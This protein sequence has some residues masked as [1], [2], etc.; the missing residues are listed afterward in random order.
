MKRRAFMNFVGLGFVATSLPVAIAACAPEPE[1]A[2]PE[3]PDSA[4][5][6]P[7]TDV[8]ARTDGFAPLGSVGDLDA[9]GFLADKDFAAGPVIVIRDPND[10]A[11]V[12]ALDSTCTHTGCAVDWAGTEFACPCHGSK[13]SPTGEV[14]N[15]PAN[16]PLGTYEAKIEGDEV[17]VKAA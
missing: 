16:A 15:G 13:F 9:A 8:A 6:E 7:A 5:A 11:S 4:A 17:L 3:E 1:A 10:S 12:I 2:T 14:T